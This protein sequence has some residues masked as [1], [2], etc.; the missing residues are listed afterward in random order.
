MREQ[1]PRIVRG[2]TCARALALLCAVAALASHGCRDDRTDTRRPLTLSYF[3]LGWSQPDEGPAAQRHSEEFARQTGIRVTHPPVPETSLS[4]LDLSRKLVREGDP[5]VDVLGIDVVWSGVLGDDLFDLRPY[6]AAELAAMDPQLLPVFTV[7]GRLVAIPYQVH[8]GVIEY[9][10]DLVRAYGFDH[11]PRTWDELE[12]MAEKI[13]AGERA[14]GQ[15]DFWGYVWQGAPSEALTCNALE[16]L[17]AEGAGNIVEADRTI[18]VNNPATVRAWQRAKRWIGWISPPSVVA[19]RE[20]DAR[21]VFDAGRAA[22]SRNW[23]GA[24]RGALVGG[25]GQPPQVFGRTTSMTG[26]FGYAGMPGGPGGRSSTLGGSGLAIPSRSTKREAAVEFIRFLVREQFNTAPLPD[27]LA[28]ELHDLPLVM[29]VRPSA[30]RSAVAIRP[31]ATTGGSY[32]PVTRAYA[33]SLHAVL[34]GEKPAAA[35]AAELEE[36]LV[37]ITGFKTGPPR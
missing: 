15:K 12:T 20:L 7:G 1:G 29:D 24:T 37:A 21:N 31:S 13:Q 23:A 28:M 3:R 2:R 5:T 9:R 6:F 4:Q 22:F 33:Q 34:T 25:A 32:E 11:P 10:T 19:Y 30:H 16:W 17:A 18:S 35:A 26:K 8:V 14:K 27:A 36:Q